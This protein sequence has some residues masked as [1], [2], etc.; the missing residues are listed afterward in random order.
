MKSEAV[1]RATC[2]PKNVLLQLFMND[3]DLVQNGWLTDISMPVDDVVK[4]R[5]QTNLLQIVVQFL[6]RENKNN[7]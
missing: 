1:A 4:L 2:S 3:F 6:S 7:L 5:H